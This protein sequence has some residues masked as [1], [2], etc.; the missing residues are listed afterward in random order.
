[1]TA[2]RFTHW[3]AVCFLYMPSASEYIRFKFAYSEVDSHGDVITPGAFN[4]GK[5][6]IKIAPN[7]P[8]NTTMFEEAIVLEENGIP[9]AE[10]IKERLNNHPYFVK[11][12]EM[13]PIIDFINRL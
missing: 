2:F 10:G 6:K 1:M 12:G 4:T 9:T 3:N 8:I 13:K 5:N 11:E 7:Q